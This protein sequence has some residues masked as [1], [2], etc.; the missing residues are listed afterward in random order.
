M[1]PE[2]PPKTLNECKSDEDENEPEARADFIPKSFVKAHDH[3]DIKS[4]LDAM[5]K[6]RNFETEK[7]KKIV[8]VSQM[9]FIYFILEY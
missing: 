9:F 2:K 4:P 3:N 7:T 8:T 6:N 5:L 1:V